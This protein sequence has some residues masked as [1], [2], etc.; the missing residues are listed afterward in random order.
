MDHTIAL[1][2]AVCNFS[3][4]TAEAG[5]VAARCVEALDRRARRLVRHRDRLAEMGD[6]LLEGGAA[7][8]LVARLAP[9]FDR[10]VVEAGFSEVMGDRF[11]L[12]LGVAAGL[13]RRGGGAPGGGS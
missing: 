8:G 9:P 5:A 11:G 13:R 12:G 4:S 2:E 3:R 7:Q 1:A 10:E 6:R